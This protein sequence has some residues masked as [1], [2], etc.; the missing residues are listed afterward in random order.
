[1]SESYFPGTPAPEPAPLKRGRSAGRVVFL[2]I[3]LLV[4]LALPVAAFVVYG[5]LHGAGDQQDKLVPANVDF[6][7]AAYLDPGVNQKLNVSNLAHHF[8]DTKTDADIDKQL[9]KL[10]NDAFK[11]SGLDYSKDIKPWVGNQ[12]SMA[13]RIEGKDPKYVVIIATKDDKATQAAIDKANKHG[14]K[15]TW[16]Q[17]TH[18]GVTTSS[19]D[20]T[21]GGGP[22][23]YTIYNHLLIVAN[24]EPLVDE[25]IDINKDPGHHAAL[26]DSAD[27]KAAM[28]KLP[29]ERL[30]VAY[31]NAPSLVGKLKEQLKQ[32]KTTASLLSGGQ[33]DQLDA[34]RGVGIAIAAHPDGIV[35]QVEVGVDSTKLSAEA[36]NAMAAAGHAGNVLKYV[37]ADAYGALAFGGGKAYGAQLKKLID[38]LPADAKTSVDQLGLADPNGILKHLTGEAGVD[39][40]S[41]SSQVIPAGSLLVGTDDRA[42]ARQFLDKISGFLSVFGGGA[43]A[44]PSF[45]P[46]HEAY[47]GT[48]ISS[49]TLPQGSG[50]PAGVQ[51]AW[52]VDATGMIIISTSPNELK[53]LLDTHA[54]PSNISTSNGYKEAVGDPGS[55]ASAL[56]YVDI[57]RVVS[58]IRD[59]IP[60]GTLRND[61]DKSAAQFAPLRSVGVSATNS[62]DHVS[63]RIFVVIK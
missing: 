50:A 3:A 10:L 9:T 16:K 24:S 6:Y 62:P 49:F 52:A 25:M 19:N 36:R 57:Q 61:F 8:P 23:T 7:A 48:E 5:I 63:E 40:E 55:S 53:R 60:A 15:V 12:A 44:S 59:G 35:T 27:Y 37:P 22:T 54:G 31:A 11:D 18:N 20:S 21:S 2:T 14:N 30:A 28:S 42:V 56:F 13:A 34:Y 47:K 58:A 33:L 29:S 17:S 26:H 45:K 32:D 41:S 51:P 39:V 4:V 43:P 46:N 1:M 38:S